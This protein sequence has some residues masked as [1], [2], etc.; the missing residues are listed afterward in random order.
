MAFAEI[1]VD[2]PVGQDA[3][4]LI[5][6]IDDRSAT[7]RLELLVHVLEA[8]WHGVRRTQNDEIVRFQRGGRDHEE[9]I[10]L[11][12][13]VD[14]VFRPQIERGVEHDPDSDEQRPA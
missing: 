13:A 7:S 14:E 12:S 5:G 6:Q 11:A 1:I 9:T 8:K 3:G 10:L 4:A 2:D